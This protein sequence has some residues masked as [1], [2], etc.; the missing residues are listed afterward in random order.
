MNLDSCTRGKTGP[1]GLLHR[2]QVLMSSHWGVDSILGHDTC[3]LEQRYL[4]ILLRKSQGDS[5]IENSDK[6]TQTYI[7]MDCKRV[8]LFQPQE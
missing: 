8:T 7:L 3:V 1:T 6:R 5:A 4:T 2:T